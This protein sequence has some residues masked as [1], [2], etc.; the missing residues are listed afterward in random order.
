[1]ESLHTLQNLPCYPLP[2]S[3]SLSLSP[4]FAAS[5]IISLF[6]L[7]IKSQP[8]PKPG[9][10][11]EPDEENQTRY[12]PPA[13]PRTKEVTFMASSIMDV[14]VVDLDLDNPWPS[15][16]MGFVSNPMSPF[17]I[18][19]QPCSPL[20]AFSDADNDD[21][22]SGHVNYPLFLKCLSPFLSFTFFFPFP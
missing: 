19:E 9:I 22:L 17:L 13:P 5:Q 10:M 7:F 4:P 11:P 18:S 8:Q 16:Q 1:M 6:V 2:L 20:W 21:K 3:L 12:M 14:D 15:D